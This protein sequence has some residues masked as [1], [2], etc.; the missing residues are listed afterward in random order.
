MA[1]SGSRFDAAQQAQ[2]EATILKAYR[3]QYIVSGAMEPRFQQVLFGSVDQAQGERIRNALA[4]LSYAVPQA[5]PQM[6]A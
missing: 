3:W 1:I 4:P 6:A 2:I 5:A